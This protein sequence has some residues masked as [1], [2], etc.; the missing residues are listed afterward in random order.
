MAVPARQT[1]DIA[2][3]V[4]MARAGPGRGTRD[5]VFCLALCPTLQ[6]PLPL[7]GG[8]TKKEEKRVAMQPCRV[9]QSVS[10]WLGRGAPLASICYCRPDRHTTSPYM[11]RRRPWLAPHAASGRASPKARKRAQARL[12]RPVCPAGRCAALGCLC[13]KAMQVLNPRSGPCNASLRIEFFFPFAWAHTH[14]RTM[15]MSAICEAGLCVILTIC[16]LTSIHAY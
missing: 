14:A 8:G 2:V 7:A 13:C 9:S 3:P 12:T 6:S 10:V 4:Q 11:T 5:K 15:M 1:A 16:S